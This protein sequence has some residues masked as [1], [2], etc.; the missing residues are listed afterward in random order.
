MPIQW[1]QRECEVFSDYLRLKQ[2]KFAHIANESGMRLPMGVIRKRARIGYGK[3]IP[4]YLIVINNQLVFI[5][6]KREQG[7]RLSPEQKEWL[8]LLNSLPNITA[9]VCNGAQEAIN[10]IE[11]MLKCRR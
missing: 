9:L 4:D 5:E 1:E 11:N 10:V 2:I 8:E 6:M 3:G 7:G